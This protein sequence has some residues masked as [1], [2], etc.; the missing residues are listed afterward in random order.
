[1]NS[2]WT[3]WAILHY[4]QHLYWNSEYF[5]VTPG[6]KQKNIWLCPLCFR[7]QKHSRLLALSSGFSNPNFYL[8]VLSV[9]RREKSICLR[10]TY[11]YFI[12]IYFLWLVR[13][14]PPRRFRLSVRRFLL[15]LHGSWT[16]HVWRLVQRLSSLYVSKLAF[17][18]F[19]NLFI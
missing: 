17:Y 14:S 1:M 10:I 6:R 9:P 19:L 13:N 12:Y 16:A 2:K 11:Y 3:L 4:W 5:R 7:T 15:P 8:F 18:F